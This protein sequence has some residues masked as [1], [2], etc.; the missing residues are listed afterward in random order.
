MVIFFPPWHISVHLLLVAVILVL[1]RDAGYAAVVSLVLPVQ[2]NLLQ[3]QII[4]VMR[5]LY[6]SCEVFNRAEP[7]VAVVRAVLGDGR[8]PQHHHEP[9]VQALTVST[10]LHPWLV[11][12]H[13]FIASSTVMLIIL[14]LSQS[15]H[16]HDAP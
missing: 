7:Q 12:P 2:L 11:G 6:R 4:G 15:D 14:T 13:K 16:V 10:L 8:D 3:L 5:V 1:R 9:L